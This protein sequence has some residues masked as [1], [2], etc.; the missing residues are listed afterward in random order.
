MSQ[1]SHS[2][3]S[4]CQVSALSLLNSPLCLQPAPRNSL[5]HL[6][7]GSV[8]FS[9]KWQLTLPIVDK[10]SHKYRGDLG[11]STWEIQ[12]H[13]LFLTFLEPRGFKKNSPL[14]HSLKNIMEICFLHLSAITLEKSAILCSR[15]SS[16][17]PQVYLHLPLGSVRP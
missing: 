2:Y 1:A 16:F 11:Q 7:L 9:L 5:A 15:F 10:T 6:S 4:G 17:L 8:S 14:K 12:V 3:L 13:F